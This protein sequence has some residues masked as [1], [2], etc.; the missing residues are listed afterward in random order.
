MRLIGAN[1]SVQVSGVD[2]LAAKTSYFVGD[3]P[4]KWQTHVP[5]YAKV[6]YDEVYPGVN[7]IYYGNQRQ[8]EYDFVVAPG[9]NPKAIRLRFSGAEKLKIDEQGALVLETKSGPVR[10]ERPEVYQEIAGKKRVIDGQYALQGRSTVGFEV[11]SY[12]RTRPLV[13]DPVLVY[14]TYLS[15]SGIG[16]ESYGIAVDSSGN[17]Y[18]TGRTWSADFPTVNALQS[19]NPD[20]HAASVFVAKIS[21]DGSALIY[22]TY[23][24]G[25]G[26]GGTNEEA[27]SIAV[28]SA[29]NAYVTGFTCSTD[30]PTVNAIQSTNNAG[31]TAGGESAFV[32][33]INANGSA[34]V[35]STYLS[36]SGGAN[37]TGIAVDSSSNAYV[38]GNTGIGFPTVNALQPTDPNRSG[39]C[40][41]VA[42]INADG[43]AFVYSTYLGG[44]EGAN[45]TSIAADSS[46]NA[47]VTGSTLSTDFPTVNAVQSTNAN[48][49]NGNAFIAEINANGSAF[50]YSTYLGGSFAGHATTGD[51]GESIA[52]DSAGNTYVTGSTG[53][54]NFPTVNA[55]QSNSYGSVFVAK[56]NANGSA[57]VYS[58][59][60]GG[61]RHR[62]SCRFIG[63][64]VRDWQHR[65]RFSH[66]QRPSTDGSQ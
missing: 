28:D 51:E 23:L 53:S 30:F 39:P 46:G 63:Q 50:V 31:A 11:A 59:Y 5:T 38:I 4:A 8:L 62:H 65:H 54:I 9:A 3:D 57:L 13:I 29:G 58:T 52:V 20:T 25:S 66:G 2:E 35:Y 49:A 45:G 33:K 10:F 12:D 48:S 34:L 37:G 27:K 36:G 14:S 32:T 40:A 44:S 43:S 22:S 41:F 64:C 24:G 55:L 19:T 7:L 56:I 18:V 47:H 15:G 21:A 1:P 17:A 42:K 60:L 6:K 26:C 16:T 61:Q